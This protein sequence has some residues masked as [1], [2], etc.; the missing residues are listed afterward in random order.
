MLSLSFN[1][2]IAESNATQLVFTGKQV[3]DRN[4]GRIETQTLKTL[5]VKDAYFTEKSRAGSGRYPWR[6]LRVKVKGSFNDLYVE[7]DGTEGLGC[8]KEAIQSGR[9]DTIEVSKSARRKTSKVDKFFASLG[10]RFVSNSDYVLL[11]QVSYKLKGLPRFKSQN[12]SICRALSASKR[13]YPSLV[14]ETESTHDDNSAAHA[15]PDES[16]SNQ[17][18][19]ENDH[20]Q[21]PTQRDERNNERRPANTTRRS[22]SE[23][24]PAAPQ[25]PAR[26]T[27]GDGYLREWR[28]R[29][30]ARPRNGVSVY[31]SE[32]AVFVNN[33]RRFSADPHLTNTAKDLLEHLQESSQS[34]GCIPKLTFAGHGW[35][36][37]EGGPGLPMGSSGSGLYSTKRALRQQRATRGVWPF[38]RTN[39]RSL[40][41]LAELVRRGR[42]KFCS[43]CLIQIH[44]C[45]IEDAF[46][47][48]LAQSTGCQVITSSGQAAPV[49]TRDGSLD[50]VWLSGD[51]GSGQYSGWRRF[52][53]VG[54]GQISSEE[55][56]PRY[57]AE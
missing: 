19:H 37:P 5:E 4:S 10:N 55:I 46:G 50:H 13:L 21:R 2:G 16:R 20:T 7:D 14:E 28:A 57:V 11:S 25:P 41:D 45:N 47:L 12:V 43:R 3:V 18:S 54:G 31:T 34:M 48:G 33:A 49:D 17:A 39:A 44:A 23:E 35:S 22:A 38:R 6:Q 32:A 24:E 1:I 15:A 8:L 40:G 42:V 56:G 51:D 36:R 26:A 29:H 30:G 53:P 27:S 9:L 52:T